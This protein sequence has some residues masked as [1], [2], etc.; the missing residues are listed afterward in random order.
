MRIINDSEKE[1]FSARC[2]EC[3]SLLAFSR[4]D[5]Y[6]PN[7]TVQV[8]ENTFVGSPTSAFVV[9]PKCHHPIS[10]NYFYD[11]DGIRKV[12]E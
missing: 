10:E 7:A 5:V 1:V 12:R 4:N 6:A 9:C 8:D 2:Q 11:L 3:W